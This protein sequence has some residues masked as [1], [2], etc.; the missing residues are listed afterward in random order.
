MK[1]RQKGKHEDELQTPKDSNF[2]MV[3][4]SRKD[5]SSMITMQGNNA[6]KKK[7]KKRSFR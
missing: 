1:K 2:K 4:D 5:T 6:G 7:K 3:F